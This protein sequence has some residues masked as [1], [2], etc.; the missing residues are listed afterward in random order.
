MTMKLV[1]GLKRM[2][3]KVPEPRPDEVVLTWV[4][5]QGKPSMRV[6]TKTGQYFYNPDGSLAEHIPRSTR[7]AKLPQQ[8]GASKRV[9]GNAD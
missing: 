5:E 7:L 1:S 6:S 8:S 2:D 9:S 4:D 3:R